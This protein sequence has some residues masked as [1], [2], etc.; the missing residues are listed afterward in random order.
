M[1][2]YCYCTHPDER[3]LGNG[4]YSGATGLNQPLFMVV[5]RA[6]SVMAILQLPRNTVSYAAESA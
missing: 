6:E 1:Q 5:F 3:R 2:H 4:V